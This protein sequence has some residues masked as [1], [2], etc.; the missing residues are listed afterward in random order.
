MTCVVLSALARSGGIGRVRSRTSGSPVSHSCLR[1]YVQADPSAAS[2]VLNV[3]AEHPPQ[4]KVN[5]PATRSGSSVAVLVSAPK[6]RTIQSNGVAYPRR[7]FGT[8]IVPRN[9]ATASASRTPT[10]AE[11]SARTEP[12]D[13]PPDYRR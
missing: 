12:T 5:Q 11:G 10:T 7:V 1:Q 9:V 6:S 3:L 13:P 2:R 8:E 4:A